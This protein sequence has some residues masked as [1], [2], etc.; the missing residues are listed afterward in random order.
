MKKIILSITFA[1]GALFLFAQE[2][3]VPPTAKQEK[4]VSPTEKTE[5][6]GMKSSRI[7][8]VIS[9]LDLSDEEA[10][11]FR[12]LATEMNTELLALRKE[13]GGERQNFDEIDDKKAEELLDKMLELEKTKVLLTSRYMKQIKDVIGAKKTMKFLRMQRTN[14]KGFQGGGDRRKGNGNGNWQGKRG[15]GEKGKKGVKKEIRKQK[16]IKGKKEEK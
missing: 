14:G 1:L 7:D 10:E 16:S 6:N 5:K 9:R 4:K 2:K 8:H 12:P 3:K 13:L 15:I 11:A